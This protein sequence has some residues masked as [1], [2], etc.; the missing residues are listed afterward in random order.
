MRSK[1][2]VN[3]YLLWELLSAGK[4]TPRSVACRPDG[5]LRLEATQ[6]QK[7]VCPSSP[8]PSSYLALS[9]SSQAPGP[10]RHCLACSAWSGWPGQAGNTGVRG[11]R[12]SRLVIKLL[13]PLAKSVP[14]IG[15]SSSLIVFGASLLFECDIG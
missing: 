8:S 7:L 15:T 3:S 2:H 5:I 6:P 9:S 10:C 13:L 14:K 12:V 1:D 4:R 11:Q